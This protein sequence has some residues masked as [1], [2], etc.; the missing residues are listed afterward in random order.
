MSGVLGVYR[1][2]GASFDERL[3]DGILQRLRFRGPEFNCA[4]HDASS[5]MLWC[6]RDFVGTRPF[7]YS[8]LGKV[9]AF[10][11]VSFLAY[12]DAAM[13]SCVDRR[14]CFASSPTGLAARRAVRR[15]GWYAARA[16]SGTATIREC[17]GNSSRSQ[18][19]SASCS[20]VAASWLCGAR[21][22]APHSE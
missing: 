14:H 16:L 13:R 2:D 18:P 12:G 6:A 21:F 22:V 20:M 10:S 7:C 8:H 1:Q 3:L 15:R 5:K 9:V 17:V 11:N 4:L 19:V